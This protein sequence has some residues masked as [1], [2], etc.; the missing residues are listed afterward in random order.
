MNQ[1]VLFPDA[2][3]FSV[4]ELEAC[5]LSGDF[6]PILFEWYKFVGSACAFVAHIQADS[7]VIR[8]IAP[9]H[10]ATVTGLLNRCARLMLSNVALSHEGLFGETT[11]I[12][13]RCIFESAIKVIWLC[14]DE[15]AGERFFRYLADGLQTEMEL[16]S[17][18][19]EAIAKRGATM[20]IEK[21]M[22]DSIARHTS[23]A[24]LSE[25]D[26][27]RAKRLP[28]LAAMLESIGEDRLLYVVGQRL[29]SHHIHGT[30][31]SLL[32]HYLEDSDEGG[33]RPRGHNCATHVNQ[34][35]LVPILVLGAMK[36]FVRFAIECRED[37]VPMEQLFDSIEDE[38]DK[39]YLEVAAGDTDMV[40]SK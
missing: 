33:L 36:G 13:D 37:A 38:L 8:Q 10:F 4:E 25:T 16:K 28:S 32:M 20:A 2:P 11:A 29:G 40:E 31:P 1:P 39:I 9:I 19:H 7:P 5:R 21:R 24:G 3:Q 30:W 26:I 27:A 12:V 34:Y 22:L 35:M 18:I 15:G 17:W 6:C 14:Q 23:R